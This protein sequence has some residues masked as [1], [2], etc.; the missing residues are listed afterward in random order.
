MGVVEIWAE[1]EMASRF[2]M[3]S[4]YFGKGLSSERSMRTLR[5]FRSSR[6][7]KTAAAESWKPLL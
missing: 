5:G 4:G 3:A 6:I 2:E 1:S 7:P